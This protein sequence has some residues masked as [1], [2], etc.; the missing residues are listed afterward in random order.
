M[1]VIG[2]LIFLVHEM[3]HGGA[4]IALGGYFPFVQIDADGGRSIYIFPSGSASWKEALVL[5]AGPAANFLISVLA[6]AFVAAG[7]RRKPVKLLV[8]FT[9]GLAALMLVTGAGLVPPWWPRYKETGEAFY[10]LG[11]PSVYQ[12]AIKIFWL[13][14]GLAV[15]VGFFRLFFQELGAYFQVRSYRDRLM[16]VTAALGAP[17][18]ILIIIFSMV[19]LYSGYGEGVITIERHS[20]HIAFLIL[21]YFLLP[22]LLKTAAPDNKETFKLPRPQF[23][24]CLSVALVFGAAQPVVFGNDRI[25]PSGLFLSNKPPEVTVSACN[26][27]VIVGADHRARIQLLMRAFPKEHRFLWQRVKNDE[28]DDWTYYDGFAEETLPVLLGVDDIRIIRHYS[29]QEAP[30]FNGSW[31]SG[32]RIVEAEFDVMRLPRLQGDQGLRVL[33]FSDSWKQKGIGYIDFIGVS[34]EGGYT[35]GGAGTQPSGVGWPARK[36]ATEVEWENISIDTS[37]TI[38]FVG[39]KPPQK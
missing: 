18:A 23:A 26:V 39:I 30:F 36:S 27:R 2:H 9:G 19:M 25:N 16:L 6:M 17:A 34:L 24:A 12:Y 32:A 35:V 3:A 22:L 21:T 33:R 38:A 11:L 31:D 14:V 5:L 13:L 15:L 28:P 29:D 8:I 20:P 7:I 4:A 37:P 10:L 1:Y